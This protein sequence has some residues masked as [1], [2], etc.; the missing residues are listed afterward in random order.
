MTNLTK[1]V[2]YEQSRLL[3][4]ESHPPWNACSRMCKTS[5]RGSTS[6]M[7]VLEWVSPSVEMEQDGFEGKERKPVWLSSTAKG[8]GRLR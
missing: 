2:G 4:A 7:S 3:P 5:D 8:E 1:A 6:G